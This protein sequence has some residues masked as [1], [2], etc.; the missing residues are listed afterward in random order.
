M[1]LPAVSFASPAPPAPL[2]TAESM[3]PP[4]AETAHD[5]E[6][7]ERLHLSLS[8]LFVGGYSPANA[9]QIQSLQGG[10]HDPKRRGFTV[11]SVEQSVWGRVDRYLSAQAHLVFHIDVDGAPRFE[12]KEAFATTEALPWG[13]KAKAGT[14]LTAFGRIN[15]QH[16]HA[17][18]FVD[19]P[20]INSRLLGGSGLHN[21]GVSM[22]WQAPLPWHS[23]FILGM[24]AAHGTSAVSFLGEP[25]AKQ[26]AGLDLGTDPSLNPLLSARWLNDVVV[27]QAWVLNLG[28]SGIVGPNATAHHAQTFLAGADLVVRWRPGGQDAKGRFLVLQVEAMARR[29][30]IGDTVD[31]RDDFGGY[32][33]MVWGFA[34]RWSAALRYDYA[35][36]TGPKTLEFGERQRA[37]ANITWSVS[38]AS[39]L[40]LQYNHDRAQGLER[41]LGHSGWLQF[42]FGLG[43]HQH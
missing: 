31:V 26:Y 3:A 8:G 33:Q 2:P 22:S 30:E 40:R 15:T 27:T 17:W 5:T 1:L 32:A 36:G 29:Y 16:P 7:A 28:V 13:L 37:S 11:Q 24:Q 35:D 10:M 25:R 39:R 14:F 12:L 21:P 43:A 9:L 38:P 18:H 41:R 19:Q 6:P 42:E 23:H 34:K 4:A 20:V